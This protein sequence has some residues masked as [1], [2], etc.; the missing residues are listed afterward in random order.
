[1]EIT[2]DQLEKCGCRMQHRTRRIEGVTVDVK[3]I[4]SMCSYHRTEKE[5]RQREEREAKEFPNKASKQ[6]Y[7]ILDKMLD[8]MGDEGLDTSYFPD[9][10]RQTMKETAISLA[11]RYYYSDGI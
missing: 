8:L 5:R 2:Y 4:L 1:M 7:D 6:I 9:N 10:A 3:T 11:E